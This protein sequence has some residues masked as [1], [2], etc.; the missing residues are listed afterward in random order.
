MPRTKPFSDLRQHIDQE[1]ERRRRVADMKRA[2]L[3][4]QRLAEIRAHRGMTQQGVADTLA[5]SQANV[6]RIEYEDDLYLST[7]RAYVEALGGTLD[8]SARFPDGEV[9]KVG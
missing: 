1:P 2:M 4:A 6:S 7:L 5:V 9:I 8:I 3:D